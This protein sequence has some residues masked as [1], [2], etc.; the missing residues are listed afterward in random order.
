MTGSGEAAGGGPARHVSPSNPA[1]VTSN[2]DHAQKAPHL[3]VL[4]AEVL[5]ALAPRDDGLYLDGTFGA[6]GYTRALLAA[7]DCRVLALDRDPTAIANG[8]ALVAEAEGRL[9][10]A[11]AEFSDMEE[12]AAEHGFVGFDGIV[13]DIGVSSMQ[14][15]Q[16]Q[17]GFSFR[18]EG[19]LDMRMAQGG[20]LEGASAADI[21][22]TASETRL[23]DI[24]YHYGEE[25]LSRL[26]ARAI[27][28]DRDATPFT[29]TKQLADLIG[30]I[31][32]TKPGDIHPATRTFQAL[33]IAV[34]DELNE[35]AR[36]LHAA[37][38]LLKPGGRLVIV[39]FHSLEDRI[40]KTFFAAR[41]GRGGGS[42]HAPQ[43]SL[44]VAT[45]RI[46]GK[47]PVTAGEAELAVNPRA[48]SAKL[49]MAIRTDAAPQAVDPAVMELASL[50]AE[51]GRADKGRSDR[52]KSD[53]ASK[54]K[55]N[56]GGRR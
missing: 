19:P 35:L 56:K 46:E 15:D 36:A 17:R 39:S 24:F 14:L 20:A 21:V 9:K 16:A 43:M 34:N 31:V 52:G 25:R 28:T 27:V 6:G 8:Q 51:K 49:R 50:P 33:R 3:P 37:E 12:V 55:G 4:L 11:E 42:R 23:A 41:A 45:F 38:R 7:A 32:R 18:F 26:I 47:W 44:P 48:R 5:G 40:A 2:K 30:R 1:T 13:L 53:K 10:L 29:T 22:N 54:S